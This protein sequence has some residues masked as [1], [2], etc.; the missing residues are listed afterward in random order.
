PLASLLGAEKQPS[1]SADGARVAFVFAAG[2]DRT[3][4]IYVKSMSTTGSTRLTT[5]ALSDLWPAF[6]PDGTRLAFLRPTKGKLK[7]MVMPSAGGIAHQ[8][9]EIADLLREYSMMT[10]DATGQN[11]F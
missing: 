3:N 4:H 10:W 2:T 1:I 11:L 6:S 8:S 5:D 7:V 9:G